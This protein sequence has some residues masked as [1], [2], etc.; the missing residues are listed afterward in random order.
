MKKTITINLNNIVFTIDDDA[1]DLLQKYLDDISSHFASDPEKDEIMNDIEGRIAELFSERL[2]KSKHVV[3]LAD[4][5]EIMSILGNPSQFVD[6]DAEA[7]SS[8]GN[9]E[10]EASK[11]KD[12]TSRRFYRDPENAILGGIGGGLAA[13]FNMDVTVMRVIMVIAFFLLSALGGGW[14]IAITYILLWII[15]PQARTASQRLEMQ[16]EEVTVENI[17]SEFNN[18]KNYVESENF[19]QSTKSIG[20]RLVKIFVTI[21]KIFGGFFAAVFSF[22]GFVIIASLIAALVLLIFNPALVHGFFPPFTADWFMLSPEKSI[23]LLIALLLVVGCPIFLVIYWIVRFASGKGKT[24][25]SSFWVVLLLWL[26][27]LF[28][29]I[30]VSSKTIV[31]FRN[32]DRDS[33]NISWESGNVVDEV[34]NC[35]KFHGIK[36][37]GNIE[38]KLTQDTICQVVLSTY[39]ELLPKINTEVKDGVLNVYSSAVSL[40]NPVV[41]SITVDSIS[42]IVAQG[43]CDIK[44]LS[45]IRTSS[46]L[47]IALH[48]ASKAD[49]RTNVLGTIDMDL[50]GASKVDLEGKANTLKIDAAGASKI[51]AEDLRAAHVFI[52]L[53]GASEADVYASESI[54]AKAAGASKIKCS[55]KPKSVINSTGLASSFHLN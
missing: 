28:M 21:L 37:S 8:E 36:V 49:L 53:G 47:T 15:A 6:G 50:K 39:S 17:K 14:F 2:N 51:S 3:N 34:R 29:L 55:G 31:D 48:G 52:S 4:V 32:F 18:F 16:G 44:T 45:E 27:G 42:S 5:Q 11:K 46:N 19:K 43:A 23:L 12:K 40:K 24:S 13:Y 26:A 33:W 22:V 38:L 20:D 1:Y 35:E 41:L 7:D 10:A 54:D 30:S 25:N 9:V